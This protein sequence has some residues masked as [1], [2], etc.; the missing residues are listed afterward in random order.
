MSVRLVP[1]TENNGG[2]IEYDNTDITVTLTS[3]SEDNSGAISC[4]EYFTTKH[5]F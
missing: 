2:A 3:K 1:K 4:S 5:S